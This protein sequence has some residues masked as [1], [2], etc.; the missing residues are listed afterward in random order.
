MAFAAS[1]HVF[2]GGGVDPRDRTPQRWAGPS[3]AQ[4]AQWMDVDQPTAAGLV[5]AAVRELF[6]ECGVLLAGAPGEDVVADLDDESWERDRLALLSRTIALTDLLQQRGLEL[7]TDLLTLWSHWCT[8]VFEPRRYDTWFF[9]AELPAGQRARHVG[10]EAE[11]STWLPAREA[12]AA[13]ADGRLAMMPPTVVTLEDVA[14]A[15][16]VADLHG[17][18]RQLRLLM[19]W[20][21]RTP[22]GLLLRVDLDGGGGG[23]PGPPSGLEDAG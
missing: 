21:V 4:W 20:L 12:A 15:T 6:E 18:P 1:Q 11:H 19:P 14:G 16:A 23:E 2:P 9:V 8:P 7:R 17:R 22:Q 3:L 13:G 10:G 5:C